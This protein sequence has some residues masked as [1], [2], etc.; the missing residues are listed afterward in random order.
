MF[1]FL[2][3]TVSALTLGSRALTAGMTCTDCIMNSGSF[4]L[5]NDFGPFSLF[6]AVNNGPLF[7]S[8]NSTTDTYCCPF[9]GCSFNPNDTT[10]L[11]IPDFTCSNETAD[12]TI[13]LTTC[14]FYYETC[15]EN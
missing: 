8:D 11:Q 2:V 14:P 1:V 9:S 5:S 10:T 13:A 4:C 12:V 15:S 6:N 7:N 3:S